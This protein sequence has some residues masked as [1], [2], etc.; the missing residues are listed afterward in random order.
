[1]SINRIE[2]VMPQPGSF[3]WQKYGTLAQMAQA[4][5]AL[6]GFKPGRT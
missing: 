6:L 2:N 5:V 3:W 4:G 1:L